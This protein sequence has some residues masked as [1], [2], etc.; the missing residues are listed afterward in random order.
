MRPDERARAVWDNVAENHCTRWPATTRASKR[1]HQHRWV[2]QVNA[3]FFCRGLKST[4]CCPNTCKESSNITQRRSIDLFR[5]VGSDE[6]GSSGS[7]STRQCSNKQ[8]ASW[9]CPNCSIGST[10]RCSSLDCA[11]EVQYGTGNVYFCPSAP[12]R[13]KRSHQATAHGS[14]TCTTGVAGDLETSPGDERGRLRQI[15]TPANF[16]FGHCLFNWISHVSRPRH[17][18]LKVASECAP[19]LFFHRDCAHTAGLEPAVGVCTEK[20]W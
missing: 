17:A 14:P 16:D 19:Q 5:V 18:L 4:A 1:P 13:Q 8:N 11:Y 6:R 9:N 2:V 20:R 7:Q 3:F 10:R 12:S 15:S